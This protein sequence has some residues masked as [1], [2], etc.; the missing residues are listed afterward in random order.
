MQTKVTDRY[1][2]I[3]K[4]KLSG[5]DC[6]LSSFSLLHRNAQSLLLRYL[7]L[8]CRH[9]Y[10]C[11][12]DSFNIKQKLVPT[13]N[14]WFFISFATLSTSRLY[15]GP[16]G[17]SCDLS[18]LVG[19]CKPP[20]FTSA[21]GIHT[22]NLHVSINSCDLILL[23]HLLVQLLLGHTRMVPVTAWTLHGGSFQSPTL[24]FWGRGLFSS[25]DTNLQAFPTPRATGTNSPNGP[26]GSLAKVPSPH[27]HPT[28]ALDLPS[29][30]IRFWGL[31]LR[32]PRSSGKGEGSAGDR[33]RRCS[34]A[35]QGEV[36][37][38]RAA[39]VRLSAMLTSVWLLVSRQGAASFISVNC[40]P[41]LPGR[42]VYIY[43]ICSLQLHLHLSW[44]T[45]T[46]GETRRIGKWP[47]YEG[48]WG[49]WPTA[50]QRRG[51]F[52]SR[53][54][55]LSPWVARMWCCTHTRRRKDVAGY[56][57]GHPAIHFLQSARRRYASVAT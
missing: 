46:S 41:D 5:L 56:L 50:R 35:Q 44:M 45:Q 2:A 43:S 39:L 26:F 53:D 20:H 49:W 51:T 1:A 4:R 22:N 27:V 23:D 52:P 8:L 48:T 28:T 42:M 33:G 57:R 38:H 32:G 40:Q 10:R 15:P 16:R 29:V 19:S 12:R 7:E 17:P 55:R 3:I 14:F 31:V 54:M 30:W 9:F 47:I 37:P 24:G 13:S 18:L 6:F 25:P 34:E 36:L 11:T 21:G